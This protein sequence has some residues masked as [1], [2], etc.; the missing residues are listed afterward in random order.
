[1]FAWSSSLE[2]V[3]PCPSLS[4]MR[5][6]EGAASTVIHTQAQLELDLVGEPDLWGHK[7]F[8]G[9][10]C[11]IWIAHYGPGS[12]DTYNLA[13]FKSMPTAC[14]ECRIQALPALERR[15]VRRA[16]AEFQARAA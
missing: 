2:V 12:I 6:A 11:D 3:R 16:I 10:M 4:T 7:W 1:M 9:P 15:R 5:P 13:M 14:P 8:C